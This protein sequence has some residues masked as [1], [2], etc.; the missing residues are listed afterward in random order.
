MAVA[1]NPGLLADVLQ[2]ASLLA[3][4]EAPTFVV[5]TASSLVLDSVCRL[6]RLFDHPEDQAV[7][8]GAAEGELLH[9]VPQTCELAR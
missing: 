6:V 8:A 4:R 5:G 1:L 7:L 9:R 2:V 3:V